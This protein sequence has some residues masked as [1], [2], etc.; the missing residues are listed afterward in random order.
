MLKIVFSPEAKSDLDEIFEHILSQDPSAA[1]E[2]LDRIGRRIA[3]LAEL[4]QQG[5]P[6]RVPGTR[7]LV[8]PQTRFVFPY[9]V[10]GRTIEILRVYHGAR[11]WPDHF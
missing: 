2:A 4:P 5:R 1:S 3:S 8:I 7:E 10:T 6:G 9:Q 11:T